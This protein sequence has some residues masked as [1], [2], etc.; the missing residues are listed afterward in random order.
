[1]ATQY[2]LNILPQALHLAKELLIVSQNYEAFRIMHAHRGSERT[3]E[4]Q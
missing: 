1:M 3:N 4:M 2:Q